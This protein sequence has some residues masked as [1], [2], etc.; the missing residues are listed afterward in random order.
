MW[1]KWIYIHIY[2]LDNIYLQ[3]REYN[4]KLV[5][6]TTRC[7]AAAVEGLQKSTKSYLGYDQRDREEYSHTLFPLKVLEVF[8]GPK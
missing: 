7:F 3:N 4:V 6:Q 2:I 8:D 5:L 1:Y